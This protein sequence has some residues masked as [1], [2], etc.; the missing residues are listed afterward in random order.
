VFDVKAHL[1]TLSEAHAVSGHEAPI[2]D[3]LRDAWAG[4]VDATESDGL[5]SLIGIKR[6]TLPNPHGRKIMLAAHMDEIGLMVRDIVD[7]FLFVTPVAGMDNRVLLAK[8]V[9]VHGTRPLK[10]VVAATPPHLLNSTQANVH[11]SFAQ[12]VVDVGLPDDVVRAV[13]KIGDIV[14]PD[15][16]LLELKNGNLVGKAFD[17]R[18]CVTAVTACLHL[19]KGMA[20]AFDVYAVATVQEENGLYGAKTAAQHIAP[21]LAIALDVGFAP[22]SGV[23]EHAQISMGGGASIAIGSNIH[24]KM[25]EALVACAKAHEIKHQIEPIVANSGTDAWAIQVALAGIPTALLSLPLRNMHSQNE[26]CDPQDIERMARL[27]AHFIASLD[28]AFI[29]RLAL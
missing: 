21:D 7:G 2:A 13:V 18:A 5:G 22:Q 8:P 12:L 29:D 27:L 23:P 26:T 19:L 24:P 20:H 11:P 28:E 1:K 25:F 10:G 14:T 6:A 16:T 9:L 17:D 3:I 4:L 15:V